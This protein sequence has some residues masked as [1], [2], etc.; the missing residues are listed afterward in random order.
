VGTGEKGH[1]TCRGVPEDEIDRLGG[2][3]VVVG[4][5]LIAGGPSPPEIF[6]GQIFDAGASGVCLFARLSPQ[7]DNAREIPRFEKL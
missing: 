2:S 7:S 4:T 6:V 5:M 1:G 3:L